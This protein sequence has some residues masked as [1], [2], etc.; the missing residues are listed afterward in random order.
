MTIRIQ[1]LREQVYQY[2]RQQMQLGN[3]NPGDTIDLNA[4]SRELG[5]SKTPLRDALIQLEV[6]GFVTILPRRGVM[7]RE[8]TLEEVRDC[9]EIIGALEASVVRGVFDAIGAKEIQA[10]KRLNAEQRMAF[11]AGVHNLYYQKNLDFHSVFLNLSPNA[12][13]LKTIVPMKLRLYDFPRQAYVGQ[14]EQRNMDEHDRFI[15]MIEAGDV[16]GA[17]GLLKDIHWSYSVQEKY[18]RKFYRAEASAP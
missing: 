10:M 5:V 16:D 15:A 4:M 7:V 12:T 6:E 14:W 17:A 8:L 1:S 9:Y 11:S 2:F 18:I 3:L 13:L